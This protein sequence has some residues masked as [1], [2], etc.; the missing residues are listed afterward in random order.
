LLQLLQ[1]IG[2]KITL[3]LLIGFFNHIVTLK[4]A[5]CPFPVWKSWHIATSK[6]RKLVQWVC[7]TLLKLMHFLSQRD[8]ASVM[9]FFY[10]LKTNCMVEP[11]CFH[12]KFHSYIFIPTFPLEDY[13][14]AASG[15]PKI[16]HG[17]QQSQTVL[18]GLHQDRTK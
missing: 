13:E 11:C 18:V 7:H 12:P 9:A 6:M 17:F 2:W 5:L 10:L 4:R 3:K 15:R 14:T 8:K 1:S 16:L